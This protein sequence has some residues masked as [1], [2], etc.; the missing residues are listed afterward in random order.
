MAVKV[1]KDVP[2]PVKFPFAGMQVGDSF[3]V[4]PDVKRP[5][6]TVAAMRFGRRHGVKFTVRQVADKTYRCWRIE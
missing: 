1:E 2:L 3:A 6:V 5:A 4:P